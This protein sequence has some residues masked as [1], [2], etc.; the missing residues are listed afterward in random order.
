MSIR[1][2]L[3]EDD[4]MD[5]ELISEQLRR[6]EITAEIDRVWDREEYVRALDTK[7]YDL[8]LADYTLPA[9]DGL[10][11]LGITR[12]QNP[13]LP[14]VIVSAT[15]DEEAAINAMREG[16]SDFVVKG[17][18]NRL[19]VVIR[20]ALNEADEKTKRKQAERRLENINAGLELLV[21]ARTRERDRIWRVSQDLFAVFDLKG[22]ILS[23][24]PA[25]KTVLGL[26]PTLVEGK[27]DN[28]LKHPDDQD[29]SIVSLVKLNPRQAISEL[30]ERLLHEDGTYRWISWRAAAPEDGRIFAVGRDI[31]FSKQ[32]AETL[33]KAK[34]Q[35]RQSQKMEAIGQLTGGVAHDFNNLLTVIVGNMEYL[36][37]QNAAA[38]TVKGR[39]AVE[40]AMRAAQRAAKLTGS[41]LAFSR[42]QALDPRQIH[43]ND[44]VRGM[45]D[46]FAR[47]LRES[48]TLRTEYASD[49]WWTQADANQLE[50]AILNLAVNAR[51]ALAHGGV[52]TIS[53]RNIVLD[54]VFCR[55]ADVVPGDYV[56]IDVSDN[57]PGMDKHTL[58]Q[59]F[60]PFFTT[61]DIGQ[62]T[63]LGLS[64]VY[65]FVKQSGGHVSIKS[66]P[67]KGTSVGIYLPRLNDV[68]ALTEIE[69]IGINA[70]PVSGGETILLVEDEED[71]RAYSRTIL[72]EL[73]YSVLEASD[74]Q[75]ALA[76]YGESSDFDLLLTDIGLP[77]GMNGR[78]LA[79]RFQSRRPDVKV[80]FVSGYAS[81]AVVSEGK[82]DAGV[83]LLRKPFTFSALAE[84]LRDVFEGED[85]A[86]RILV[87]E[88]EPLI[89]MTM[90][91]LLADRGY[92]IDE[93]G[94]AVE[95]MEIVRSVDGR[96]DGAVLDLGLP[97]KSGDLL[98][99]E[100]REIRPDLAIIIASGQAEKEMRGRFSDMSGMGFISKPYEIEELAKALEL[101]WNRL[102][103]RS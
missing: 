86:R 21:D 76:R 14:F 42:R 85:R 24:N 13:V 82:L 81:D 71:V 20:R 1:I 92:R 59:A 70:V 10:S 89:R 88:D 19:P 45:S 48:I 53:T 90:V 80:L 64:Q 66:E 4:A 40:S 78:Q 75:D 7:A 28:E 52:L 49:L 68:Q 11:A 103:G 47:T 61:K 83:N 6:N 46:L 50:N 3:L 17:R 84:R 27:R 31:T 56:L 69:D 63:G 95:A 74:G 8:V 97:D 44:L 51:D 87:V 73:G 100:I 54:E 12:E 101:Q 67:G 36:Q 18:L 96:L 60:D 16:A 99:K 43:A 35:L 102:R 39:V 15:L 55:E 30:E 25:W 34:Q 37:R 5:A 65:G 93:A 23:A 22:I 77:N 41:L 33:A 32:Q 29:K 58:L 57:G 9:F 72:E 79:D 91:E 26:N 2:L 98:A 62:G 38:L 94:S